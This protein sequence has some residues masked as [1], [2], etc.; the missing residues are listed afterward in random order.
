MRRLGFTCALA[1]A[2]GASETALAHAIVLSST[3]RAD[4]TIRGEELA[5]E[6]RFNSRIDA[7]RSHMKLFKI[8][9][10]A[11][12]LPILDAASTDTLNAKATGLEP[13]AYRLHWQA[14][15]LDGHITQGDISFVV[16]R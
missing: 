15:S 1:F 11:V 7:A 13:G 6:I 5:I 8:G 9:G 3:P 12:A 10:D 2:L 16:S 14:L 4:Q